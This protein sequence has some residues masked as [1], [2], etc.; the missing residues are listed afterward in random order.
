MTTGTHSTDQDPS[1]I[2][3]QRT[4]LGPQ[5][6]TEGQAPPAPTIGTKH[7]VVAE[8]PLLQSP[9][10]VRLDLVAAL[11]DVGTGDDGEVG[12]RERHPGCDVGKGSA[13]DSGGETTP[14]GVHGGHEGSGTPTDDENGYAIGGHDR[15]GHPRHIGPEGITIT[16]GLERFG[17]GRTVGPSN[18]RPVDLVLIAERRIGKTDGDEEAPPVLMH[19][20]L[21]VIRAEPEIEGRIDPRADPTD[22]RRE[23]VTTRC[24]DAVGLHEPDTVSCTHREHRRH[25]RS[26]YKAIFSAMSRA[27]LPRGDETAT[28]LAAP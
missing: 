8:S 9:T 4:T 17:N 18:R 21:V 14:P 24:P 2:E 19:R 22:S 26:V 28:A 27:Y 15:Q 13:Q 23:T 5:D 12:R 7:V 11:A 25:L 10:D 3:A 20:P 6:P 16:E 1:V